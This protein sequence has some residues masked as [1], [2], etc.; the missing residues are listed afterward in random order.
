MSPR[1]VTIGET[2]VP[3]A[4]PSTADYTGRRPR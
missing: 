1:L 4:S 2:M 3:L